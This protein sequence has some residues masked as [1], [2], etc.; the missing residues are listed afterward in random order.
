MAHSD[1]DP[2]LYRRF[3][4]ERTRPA[5]DL[6][7]HVPL[8]EPTYV[9]D[10]GCGPGNSSELLH[11]RFPNAR[12]LGI[13]SSEAM[14]RSA[15]ERLP[16]C[17]FE[18]ADASTWQPSTAPDLVFAN[19]LLQWLPDHEALVPRLFRL[20]APGGVLAVQMPDNLDEPSHR[21]MREVATDSRWASA[22]GDIGKLRARILSAQRYYDLLVP[23]AVQVD[24]WRT[25]Y[26]HPMTSPGAIVDWLRATGL[27]PFLERLT[28]DQRGDFVAE[29]ERRIDEA[30]PTRADGQRLLAFPRLCMIAQRAS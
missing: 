1:W 3:E 14:V 30:Y 23:N 24:I 13:D 22:I 8:R 29:Y 5:L 16:K 7:M 9:V 27:R 20:L 26:Q 17:Q 6:L 18:I 2:G 12:I 11:S 28:D 21:L 4:T 10:L 25:T 15:R 19:A